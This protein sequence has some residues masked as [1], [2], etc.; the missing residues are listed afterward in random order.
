[1]RL[2]IKINRSRAYHSQT[3]WKDERF[4]RTL[5][6][7][8]LGHLNFTSLAYCQR[9]VDQ[10]RDRYN[11]ERPHDALGLATPTSGYRLS[12][13]PFSESL[14]PIEYSAGLEV[15]K[16]QSDGRLNLSRSRVSP[17]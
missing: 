14:P 17:E 7:E 6:F 1:M 11:L 2:R 3:Q 15:R 9:E 16:V 5:Q 12:P 13:I 10:F 8:L 4:H